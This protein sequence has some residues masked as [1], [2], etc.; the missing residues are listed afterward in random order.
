MSNFKQRSKQFEL[1]DGK[2]IPFEDIQQ[3]MQELNVI[4]TYLG[5][6]AITVKG[7]KAIIGNSTQPITIC[8]IGCGGGDNIDAIILMTRFLGCIQVNCIYKQ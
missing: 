8:E 6:H 3:N 4:N 5:G 2:N 7:V 1:L